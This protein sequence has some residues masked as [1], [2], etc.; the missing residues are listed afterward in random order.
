VGNEEEEVELDHST[1]V[2]EI[3]LVG[4]LLLDSGGENVPRGNVK[5]ATR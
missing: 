4:C 3:A 5:E 1:V 2:D